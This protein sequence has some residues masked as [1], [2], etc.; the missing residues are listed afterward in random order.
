MLNE[1][2]KKWIAALRSEKYTQGCGAL[3]VKTYRD[4]PEFCCLGV[5]CEVYREE[6]GGHWGPGV[7]HPDK[8]FGSMFSFIDADGGSRTGSLPKGV[9]DW[10]GLSDGSGGLMKNSI[11]LVGLNDR[12]HLSFAEIADIIEDDPEGLF[13]A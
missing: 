11:P 9:A 8:D 12:A 5:A 3:Q 6:V 1:H 13:R 4:D 7:P 10:L 2:A